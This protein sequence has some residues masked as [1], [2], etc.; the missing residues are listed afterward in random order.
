MN[1]SPLERFS[2]D[3]SEMLAPPKS[4][5]G[6]YASPRVVVG[7]SPNGV[8]RRDAGNCTAD[9]CAPQTSKTN[10]GIEA[11]YFSIQGTK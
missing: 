6:A 1:T 4:F 10:Q 11:D 7:V 2:R 8:F 9:A 3:V 5:R